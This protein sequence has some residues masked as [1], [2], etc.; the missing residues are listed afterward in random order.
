MD[1]DCRLQGAEF[2]SSQ[3]MRLLTEGFALVSSMKFPGS[4]GR[5]AKKSSLSTLRTLDLGLDLG[6]QT[7]FQRSVC[8]T[9]DLVQ[10]QHMP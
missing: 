10:E 3:E 8:K 9:G 5:G 6:I 7:S 1:G 4:W 2:Q